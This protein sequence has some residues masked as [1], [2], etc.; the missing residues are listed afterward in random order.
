MKLSRTLLTLSTLFLSF[1][2]FEGY[3]QIEIPQKPSK[4]MAVY[5]NAKFFKDN[6]M[7]QLRQKLE[8]YADTT[9]TQIVV[10]TINT[11]NGEYMGMY[12]AE[13]AQKCGAG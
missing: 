4:E 6:E 12:A 2:S 7:K 9:S 3:S 1:L 13:W 10:A 11:L 8:T 5:D